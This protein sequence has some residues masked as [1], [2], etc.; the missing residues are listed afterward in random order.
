MKKGVY[1]DGSIL[2][3]QCQ[4]RMTDTCAACRKP[5]C[6]KHTVE[7]HHRS[8]CKECFDGGLLMRTRAAVNPTPL[9]WDVLFYRFDTKKLAYIAVER[10]QFNRFRVT[11]ESAIGSRLA[12]A[13]TIDDD[14][15]GPPCRFWQ[16]K[17]GGWL[18]N[19]Q[20]ILAA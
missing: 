11:L 5:K 18:V 19:G 3:H 7:V 20:E 12:E 14:D 4:E 8:F 16:H 13:S 2:C 15:S 17:K 6:Q 10:E 9:W 1:S